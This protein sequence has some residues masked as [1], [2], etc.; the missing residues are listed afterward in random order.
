MT[1]SEA[2]LRRIAE[3]LAAGLTPRD[4]AVSLGAD[5]RAIRALLRPPAS[6]AYP[7]HSPDRESGPERL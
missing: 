1:T 6:P 5:E 3:M 7:H 4:I 2:T